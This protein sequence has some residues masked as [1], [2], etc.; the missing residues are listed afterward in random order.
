MVDYSQIAIAIR[1]VRCRKC[2]TNPTGSV[3][4]KKDTPGPGVTNACRVTTD[5]RTVNRV[6]VRNGGA[7]RPFATRLENVRVYRVS[8]GERAN[9][10]VRDTINIPSANV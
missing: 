8:R 6:V 9:S 2:V 10:V 1:S 7:R 3:C 4:A 5:I